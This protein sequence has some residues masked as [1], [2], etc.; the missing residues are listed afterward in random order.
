MNAQARAVAAPA[1]AGPGSL[2]PPPPVPPARPLLLPA[3]VVIAD[4]SASGGRP[5]VEAAGAAVSGGARAVWLRDRH[6]GAGERLHL[7][8]QLADLLHG[9]GGLLIASPGPGAE[10]ADLGHLGA[11]DPWAADPW[12]ADPWA[13]GD[14]EAGKA[15]GRSCHSRAG[16]EAAAAEGCSWA[17]LSPIFASGSKPGYGPALGPAALAGPPLP[18]WA[19]GGVDARNAGLCLRSGAAG[20]AVMGAVMGAPDPAAAAAAILSA[21]EEARP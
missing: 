14:G 16:L 3:L 13:A 8:A 6:L 5:L 4:S 19:L 15:R 2:V 1:R 18:V 9:V 20:V 17:T 10:L 21:V 7:A 12:A 11:A